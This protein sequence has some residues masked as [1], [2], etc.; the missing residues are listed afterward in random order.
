MRTKTPM[1]VD[2]P[3]HGTYAGH[4]AGC[5]CPACKKALH[6]YDYARRHRGLDTNDPRHGTTSGFDNGCRCDA[7]KE[8]Q[9]AFTL[10]NATAL[11]NNP[12]DKRHGSPYGYALGCRCSACVSYKANYW[13]ARKK[14]GIPAGDPK[15]GTRDGYAVGCRC[16][17][18][19]AAGK[20]YRASRQGTLTNPNDNRHGTK[21][22]YALGCRC[23]ACKQANAVATAAYRKLGVTEAQ[24]HGKI[25]A[26]ARG[27]RC[28][29]CKQAM[30]EAQR[31]RKARRLAE[32]DFT[33]GTLTGY[34]VGCRCPLCKQARAKD[35]KHTR[36]SSI[37]YRLSQNLRNRVS[38]AVK[39]QLAHKRTNTL[40]MVGLPIAALM[41]YISDRFQ[42]GMTWDNYGKW[43]IDHIRPCASFDLTDPEQ[44]KQCFHY[45]NLQPLWAEENMAK[46]DTYAPEAPPAAPAAEQ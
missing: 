27:C 17:T 5:H 45:T 18:C 37:Q 46:G 39:K 12:L 21:T 31:T 33:H 7:C 19:I 8:A 41:L 42:A 13:A 10:R 30:R 36:C 2:D 35:G 1:T 6:A 3:R 43:H 24:P 4:R 28:A 20:A 38:K 23:A 15:H 14:A 11:L 29:L 9:A 40:P 44:Q 22:G 25:S 26:Y 34:T 32:G 16:T